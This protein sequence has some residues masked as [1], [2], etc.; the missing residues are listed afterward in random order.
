MFL[1]L[2]LIRIYMITFRVNL[3]NPGLSPHFSILNLII[4]AKSLLYKVTLTGPRIRICVSGGE[5]MEGGRR[6]YSSAV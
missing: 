4:S 2:P 3:D 6:G 5:G 1:C